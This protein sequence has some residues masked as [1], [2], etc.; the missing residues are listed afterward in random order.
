MGAQQL[1]DTQQTDASEGKPLL[2]ITGADGNIG[3][4]LGKAFSRD[5]T[6]V[7]LDRSKDHED[8]PPIVEID[9]TSPQS[10]K[11]ALEKIGDK[12]GRKVAAVIHLVAFFDF[13]GEPSPKY[14]QVNVEGT[15]QL[16]NALGGFEVERFIYAS[17]M[18]VHEPQDPGER[19]DE[20]TLFDPR[21]QY[22]RS[23]KKVED[24]IRAEAQMPYAILRLAG[25][26][27]SERAVPTLSHQIARIYERSLQSHFYS[28]PLNA[29][30]SMLHRD[31]MVDAMQR[32]VERR[33]T[34]PPDAE[35][36]V[37]E[38]FAP[39]YD[40]LQDRI[41]ELIHGASEWETI[42][43]PAPVAKVGAAAQNAAEPIVPDAIDQ[44]E[45][46]FIQPFMISMADDHYALDIKRAED[47]LGWHP[48]H[49]LEDELP[50]MV[51]N[52]KRDPVSWYERN[53]ITPPQWLQDAQDE[54]VQQPEVMRE[55]IEA[56]RIAQ[57]RASRWTHFVNIALAFWLM[58]QPPLIGIENPL[59]AWAE[60]GAGAMLLVTAIASLSWRLAITRW[61]SAGIGMVVMA[62]PVLFVT[63]NATA[64]LS[65]TLVG[66]LVFGMAIAA[67]PEVG[68]ALVARRREPEIPPGW[69][70]NPSSWT[71]RLPIIALAIIGLLFSRYLAAYQMGHVDGVWEPFFA[72]SAADPQNG[73]EEIITSS[74][75]EA[76]PVPDGAVGAYIYM[77]EILTGIVGSRARWRTMPWLVMAF[78]LMIVPLGIVSIGFIIIQPIVIG[79]W[80]TLAL[81]GAAA[82]LIQ[83][84]YSVDELAASMSFIR[85]RVKA[86]KSLLR[87][88]LFGDTDDGDRLTPVEHE[89]ERGP[90][91]ILKEMWA[92]AVNLPWNLCLAGVIGLS[93]LFTRLTLEAEGSLAD[94]DH[95]L[96][97]LVITVMA[98]AAAE[99]CRAARYALVPLGLALAAAPFFYDGSMAHMAV[100]VA[101]GL[102]ITA[103]SFPRGRIVESYG[104]LDRIIR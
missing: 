6:V 84:P 51:A 10:M 16:L 81:I 68:T 31:D 61:L 1:G 57:H 2:L 100:S 36:L 42:K 12:H 83:I 82:M 4:S 98:I 60:V 71:Q 45:K 54:D 9:I 56:T 49:R 37:G 32:A 52:L 7:G 93:F 102:A 44:G 67:R 58:T 21:W 28:G 80:S 30:Q 91:T 47:W 92:G 76:W 39:G 8:G 11:T 24:L 101:G 94:A 15:R 89:F 33:S 74:V 73:T 40:T 78:G 18:L 62:L 85:R 27:D 72:G 5:F 90:M 29:G 25:I 3:R 88:V 79:T 35:I 95:L 69:S 99:V 77:L 53:G 23:K 65:D 46:P 63:P 70:F 38:P 19:I 75:S 104:S 26:Y 48:K 86:G 13:S 97:S 17:T 20:Q 66:A 55:E 22:P 64:Y 50:A 34:L 59:Y 103:L 14:D 96:G 43:L 41:G 87:V